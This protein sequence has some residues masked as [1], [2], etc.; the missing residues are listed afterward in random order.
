V[1]IG[2]VQHD[3][4]ELDIDATR[5]CWSDFAREFASRAAIEANLLVARG[6]DLVVGDIPPLAF[7]AADRAGVPS[8]ALGN[9]G[10]DWIYAVWSGFD[11]IVAC[12]RDAYAKADAL[13]RLPLHSRGGD[14]FLAFKHI[15]DLPFI[16]RRASRPAR[17][18]RRALEIS[19]TATVVL[20]SFGGF[21]AN[22]L[23]LTRLGQ[24]SDYTFVVTPPFSTSGANLPANVV[25]VNE[26]P[27]DYVSLLGACDAVVTKP[28]YGIVA[29]CLANRVAILF[30]D[31]GP[32]REYDVLA[33]ALPR[34]GKARYI[35]RLELLR[36]CL[37]PHLR[38]V[39]E[40]PA[41]WTD[42]P[43]DGAQVAADRVIS[44]TAGRNKVR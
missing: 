22:G 18:V 5:R 24:L 17:D 16:A 23:D 3:G 6:V 44:L 20:L 7:A 1:D 43:M 36:G 38:A 30:T 21:S 12:I 9:F 31:R 14:A 32:F 13:W 33:E 11:P 34:L 29:D 35:P 2:V 19:E 42:Q 4:L 28:G 40:L 15:Q 8:V 39:L 41:T 25:A 37:G 27:S 26:R 10:W